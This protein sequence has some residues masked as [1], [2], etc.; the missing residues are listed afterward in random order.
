ME[1]KYI[2]ICIF[3]LAILIGTLV[4]VFMPKNKIE[5]IID[6]HTVG[7]VGVSELVKKPSCTSCG[8]NR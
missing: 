7:N 6:T 4:Y 8:C 2:L 5:K 3:V 1:I